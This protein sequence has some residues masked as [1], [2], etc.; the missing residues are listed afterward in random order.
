MSDTESRRKIFIC[1]PTSA[2][3]ERPCAESILTELASQAYRRPV[4]E[5]DVAD[6]LVFYDEAAA[7]KGFEIG[8]RTGLQAILSSPEFLLRLEREPAGSRPGQGYRVSDLDL[9][10]RLSFFLWESAPDQELIEVATSGR[11]SD[12]AVLEQQM[13][14]MLKDPR[15]EAL[16]TRFLHLWLRLQDVGK[17]WPDGYFF[18]DFSTQL[19]EAM[20]QETELLFQY[21][22]RRT[23]ACSSSSTPTTLSSTLV[24]PVITGSRASP[25]MSSAAWSTRMT[26]GGESS[27]T[28]ACCS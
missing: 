18:P 7:E 16:A 5:E 2:A 11:L 3:E 24:W 17:V 10:T 20:V 6:L 1:R 23:G 4:T 13:G 19:A 8:V 26:G 21:L 12:P 27:A 14:R 25:E 22:V 15:S 9:A 28:G